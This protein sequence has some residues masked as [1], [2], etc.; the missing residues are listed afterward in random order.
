MKRIWILL[1]SAALLLFAGCR[2]E[3]ADAQSGDLDAE[4]TEEIAVI[5]EETSGESEIADPPKQ[6][7][8]L[9]A[10]RR[11]G[12]EPV[13]LGE[14][15]AAWVASLLREETR[16]NDVCDCIPDVTIWIDGVKMRYASFYGYLEPDDAADGSWLLYEA[17]RM[18]LNELLERNGV[19]LG[20]DAVFDA[21]E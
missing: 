12:A 21:E 16:Q 10:A 18:A 6:V 1:A 13:A 5:A 19:V 2:S 9:V 17:E 3:A 14:E 20:F 11:G 4:M 7:A 15:D 8:V